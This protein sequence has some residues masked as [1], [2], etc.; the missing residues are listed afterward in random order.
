M[1]KFQLR[2]IAIV[3]ASIFS[4]CSSSEDVNNDPAPTT[5]TP[6]TV[7]PTGDLR[8]NEA[9]E[10]V[11][12]SY[13]DYTYDGLTQTVLGNMAIFRENVSDEFTL[14][15][16]EFSSGTKYN[17]SFKR[18]TSGNVKSI[19][20]SG[21]KVSG[22]FQG[23]YKLIVLLGIRMDEG[24]VL[25]TGDNELSMRFSYNDNYQYDDLYSTEIG[26]RDVVTLTRY[27]DNGNSLRLVGSISAFRIANYNSI[28][29]NALT[30]KDVDRI[31]F[32]TTVYLESN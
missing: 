31:E 21:S 28:H 12:L 5:S 17:A 10:C 16:T 25:T 26:S 23:R 18:D 13:R 27:E 30:Y 4:G 24:V 1:S 19:D 6:T 7:T 9:A 2:I 14:Y 15:S 8:C 22:E 20:L 29:G 32:D 11:V 3:I